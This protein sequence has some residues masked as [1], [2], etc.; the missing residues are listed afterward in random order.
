MVER[1]TPRNKQEGFVGIY[2]TPELLK[3]LDAKVALTIRKW[4]RTC[5][6]FQRVFTDTICD[7]WWRNIICFAIYR[8]HHY[9]GAGWI[10]D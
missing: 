2:L 4:L 10:C 8:G 6:G 7:Y 5:N 3:K 9:I 1:K